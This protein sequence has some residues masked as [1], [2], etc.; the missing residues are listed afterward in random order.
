MTDDAGPKLHLPNLDALASNMRAFPC[1]MIQIDSLAPV[2]R[3][4]CALVMVTP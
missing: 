4:I 2:L 3:H 1:A